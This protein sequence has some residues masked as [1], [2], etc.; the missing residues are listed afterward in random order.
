MPIFRQIELIPCFLRVIFRPPD[1]CSCNRNDENSEGS[2]NRGCPSLNDTPSI[3][4][5]S[6]PQQS[7]KRTLPRDSLSLS[8]PIK[9]LRF[10]AYNEGMPIK[11][12]SPDHEILELIKERWSPRAFSSRRP[13]IETLNR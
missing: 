4:P 3:D 2:R 12:A 9:N 8:R 13:D 7:V 1:C 10:G 6:N 5:L 11:S